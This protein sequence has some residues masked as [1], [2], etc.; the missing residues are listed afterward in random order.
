MK[1]IEAL[2]DPA[3]VIICREGLHTDGRPVHVHCKHQYTDEYDAMRVSAVVGD[4]LLQGL[5][6]DPVYATRKK[7]IVQWM[8]RLSLLVPVCD[9]ET[10]ANQS[11]TRPGV[12]RYIAPALLKSGWGFWFES[13]IDVSCVHLQL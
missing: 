1:P 2:V 9:P 11:L 13:D 3:T 12:P 6:S 5:L 8:A 10:K 7:T 4:A